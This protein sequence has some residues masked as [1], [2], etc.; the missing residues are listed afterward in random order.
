MDADA[1]DTATLNA[2]KN[3]NKNI[4]PCGENIDRADQL[5]TILQ[6]FLLLLESGKTATATIQNVGYTGAF[7]GPHPFLKLRLLI[8]QDDKPSRALDAC[9]LVSN[10]LIPRIGDNCQIRYLLTDT[11]TVLILGYL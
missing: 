4:S 6:N 11:P 9:T 1:K 3:I 7:I 2:D 10:R 5:K 8:K